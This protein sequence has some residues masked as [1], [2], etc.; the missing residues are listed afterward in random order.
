MVTDDQ[1]EVFLDMIPSV[2]ATTLSHMTIA[3][4][5]MVISFALIV[6]VGDYLVARKIIRQRAEEE[7][8]KEAEKLAENEPK[9]DVYA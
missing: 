1:I 8:R 5:V 6:T 9:L 4:I 3:V 7:A 2:S